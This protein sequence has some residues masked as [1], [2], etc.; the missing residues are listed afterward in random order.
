LTPERLRV[1]ALRVIAN[2][3]GIQH[4]LEGFCH[5]LRDRV[6]NRV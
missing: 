2:V 6:S 5:Q 1:E 3:E 4:L